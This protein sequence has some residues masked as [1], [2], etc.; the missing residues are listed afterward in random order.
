[1]ED[2]TVA[3]PSFEGQ[4]DLI[5]A[6]LDGILWQV[7]AEVFW[8]PESRHILLACWKQARKQNKKTNKK[9]LL[10]FSNSM[11]I[12]YI[13]ET[14]RDVGLVKRWNSHWINH[15]EKRTNINIKDAINNSDYSNNKQYKWSSCESYVS[16]KTKISMKWLSEVERDRVGFWE[17][18]QSAKVK[19]QVGEPYQIP[20]T[21][22]SHL[23]WIKELES[24]SFFCV[25]DD[26]LRDNL[27]GT[28][29][30]IPSPNVLLMGPLVLFHDLNPSA[31]WQRTLVSVSKIWSVTLL[32]ANYPAVKEEQWRMSS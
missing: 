2:E 14:N 1:M 15:S 25:F 21:L 26:P 8:T 3:L 23:V 22:T 32:F 24:A 17:L 12:G 29:P 18:C 5:T 19:Q 9:S 28:F 11:L 10:V 4:S 16:V 7:I 13:C 31:S 20:F 27:S 30:Y 6:T